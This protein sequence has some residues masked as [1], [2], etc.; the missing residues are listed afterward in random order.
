MS[1][2]LGEDSE[3]IANGSTSSSRCVGFAIWAQHQN[4][5][6]PYD[7][8]QILGGSDSPTR[9]KTIMAA[10]F[11]RSLLEPSNRG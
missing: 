1:M 11:K 9:A 6:R 7:K 8:R 4:H 10:D 3:D 5:K 2:R